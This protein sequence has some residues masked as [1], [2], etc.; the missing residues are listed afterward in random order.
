MI[1]GF[2]ILKTQFYI[3][4]ALLLI[5]GRV[6]YK[7]HSDIYYS[8]KINSKHHNREEFYFPLL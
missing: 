3:A 8:H 1:F 7:N 6:S 4:F 5:I 2:C